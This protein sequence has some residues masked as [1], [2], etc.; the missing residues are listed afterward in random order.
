MRPRIALISLYSYHAFGI[1]S[2]YS[3]LKA[4]NT[5]VF[6]IF[7]GYFSFEMKEPTGKEINIIINLLKDLSIDAVGISVPSTFFKVASKLTL[8]I[9][10]SLGIPVIWGGMHPTLKP[11]ECIEFADFILRGE[12]EETLPWLIRLW[13]SE[14]KITIPGLWFKQGSEIKQ[15]SHIPIFYNL[16]ALPLPDFGQ[17]NKYY[18]ENGLLSSGDPL[19]SGNNLTKINDSCYH[20]INFRGCPFTCTYCGNQALKKL[21][22]NEIEFVRKRSVGKFIAELKYAK[23]QL[24]PFSFVFED[25]CFGSDKNWLKDFCTAYPKEVCIPFY[26]EMHPSLI[27]EETVKSLAKAGMCNTLI[28]IQA[29]SEKM[30]NEYFNRPIPETIFYTQAALFKKYKIGVHYEI[31]TDNPFETN[32]DKQKTLEILLNLPRPVNIHVFSL[33]F[34]PE[35]EITK[36]ALECNIITQKDVEGQS[37]RGSRQFLLD[38]PKRGKDTFWNYLYFLASDYFC[39]VENIPGMRNV[40]SGNYVLALGKSRILRKLPWL[41]KL[42]THI[43]RTGIFLK[44]KFKIIFRKRKITLPKSPFL[45]AY[46]FIVSCLAP[47]FITIAKPKKLLRFIRLNAKGNIN[48]KKINKIIRYTDFFMRCWPW[49]RLK[50]YCYV[51]SLILFYFLSKEGLAI[52][53]NFGINNEASCLKGHGWLTLGGK[54]Y[55]DD[56]DFCQKFQIMYSYPN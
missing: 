39:A 14:D 16:D 40:L 47:V 21:Y 12:A 45:L 28:G 7:Y 22:G 54:P 53:I 49:R 6:C 27:D 8:G 56:V 36:K 24:Q 55:L 34:L 38:D 9:K 29:G 35:T 50:N 42:L 30:R 4:N 25:A 51:R 41:P 15:N 3:V 1:R 20:T 33:N 5:E 31:I 18:I 37:D 46:V 2:L 48:E 43:F 23:E 32:I 17:R 26:C 19:Y 10:K 44:R 13:D 11:E 52:K